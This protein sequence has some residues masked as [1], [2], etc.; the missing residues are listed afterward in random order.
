M[1]KI[2]K[3]KPNTSNNKNHKNNLYNNSHNIFSKE[4][5]FGLCSSPGFMLFALTL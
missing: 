3:R 4:R 2:K 1:Q 5:S